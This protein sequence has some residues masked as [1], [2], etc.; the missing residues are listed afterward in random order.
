MPTALTNWAGSHTY[1]AARVHHPATVD[2]LRALLASARNLRVLGTRHTFT[3]IGDADELVSLAGLPSA[4]AVDPAGATVACGAA[5]TYGELAPVLEAHGLALPALASLPHIS[6]AGAIATATHGSGDAHGNLA[7]AV[8]ELELVTSEGDVVAVRRGDAAFPGAVVHLGALGAVTRVTLATQPAVP[9]T[10]RVFEGMPWD[11]LLEHLDAIFAAGDSVSVFTRWGADVDQVWVKRRGADT[12]A[13]EFFGARAAIVDRHPILEL[14]PANCTAQLGRPGPW[15]D[16]LPHFRLDSRPSAG[17]ELQSEYFVGRADARA[18]IAAVRAIGGR[19]RPLLL[20]SEL[21]TIAGDDLWM[22]PHHTRDSL[23]IHFTW[24]RDPA[25]VG[26][27]LPAVEDALAPF[28]ARPH[29][30]KVFAAPPPRP[31]RAGD[32]ERLAAELDPRGLFRNAWWEA[33]RQGES[34][35]AATGFSG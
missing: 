3:A 32:F 2:E 14:D 25:G 31:E 35:L 1:R 29:W 27:V 33:W 18:A 22:S 17:E 21:R 9:L 8:V 16:R 4:V 34:P 24:R 5:T 20:V 15:W 7:T 10:Q 28:G 13:P 30:G 23:G 19:L 12:P 6:V 11:A 26:A